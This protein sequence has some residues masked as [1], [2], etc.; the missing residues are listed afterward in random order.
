ML[1]DRHAGEPARPRGVRSAPRAKVVTSP[2]SASS[3]SRPS[4]RDEAPPPQPSSV[5]LRPPSDSETR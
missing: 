3:P 2:S 1:F 4:E 5:C